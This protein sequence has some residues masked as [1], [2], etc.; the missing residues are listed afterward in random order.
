MSAEKEY[1]RY[2]WNEIKFE[3]VMKS[4]NVANAFR[5][6]TT[7]THALL[8]YQYNNWTAIIDYKKRMTQNIR[9]PGH[10]VVFLYT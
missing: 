8:R 1:S 4:L 5:L 6:F 7:H 9:T 10:W 2:L 3:Y